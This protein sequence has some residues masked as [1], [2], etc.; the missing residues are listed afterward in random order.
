MTPGVESGTIR[1]TPENVVQT[2]SLERSGT[3]NPC[4]DSERQKGQSRNQETPLMGKVRLGDREAFS[5]LC[6]RYISALQAFFL[7]KT[8]DHHVAEDLTQDVFHQVWQ[9]RED[10]R[11]GTSDLAYLMGFARI[12]TKRHYSQQP[13]PRN[14]NSDEALDFDSVVDDRIRSP[15]E[16]AQIKEQIQ[17]LRILVAQLP[18]KQRL[19]IEMIHLNGLSSNTAAKRL[20]CSEHT[21]RQNSSFGTQKLKDR[22]KA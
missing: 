7:N 20:S 8:R 14:L 10:Y 3:S 19:A 4:S 12:A 15:Q 13:V 11:S 21:I 1:N 5:T 6:Q 2:N 16:Q 17:A 22:L 9:K 18:K